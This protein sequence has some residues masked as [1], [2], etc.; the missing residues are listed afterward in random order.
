M[1][2]HGQLMGRD[3]IKRAKKLGAYISFFIAHIPHWGDVHI[4]N[5]GMERAAYISAAG[6]AGREGVNY[7][8]H[9][10]TPVLPPDMPET[11]SAAVNRRTSSGVLLGESEKISTLDALKA[12][13]LN[14]ARQY[15]EESERGSIEEGKAADFCLLSADPLE[16]KDDEIKHIKVISLYKSAEEYRIN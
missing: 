11:M 4:K 5:F 6:T 2:I 8:F 7:T 9:Q 12:V 14:A 1:I 16:V 10:D 15:G 13:T 3:Q